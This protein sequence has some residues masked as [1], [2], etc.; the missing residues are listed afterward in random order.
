VHVPIVT[1][2]VSKEKSQNE[3]S[4]Y[5]PYFEMKPRRDLSED[6]DDEEDEENDNDDDVVNDL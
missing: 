5:D 2:T 6:D 4:D 1:S 3:D